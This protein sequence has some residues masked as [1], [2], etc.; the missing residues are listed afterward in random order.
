MS[1]VD[2]L[3]THLAVYGDMKL[4]TGV[5]WLLTKWVKEEKGLPIFTVFKAPAWQAV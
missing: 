5:G 4:H 2:T 1:L 3:Q